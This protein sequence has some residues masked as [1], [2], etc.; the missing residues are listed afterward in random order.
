MIQN[1]IKWYQKDD[2]NSG[3]VANRRLHLLPVNKRVRLTPALLDQHKNDNTAAVSRYLE[4][5]QQATDINVERSE[6]SMA[7][8]SNIGVKRGLCKWANNADPTEVG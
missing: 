8:V 2:H 5:E 6:E 7:L 4:V 1:I 3:A